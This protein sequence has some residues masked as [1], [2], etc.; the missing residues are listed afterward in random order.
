[1]KTAKVLTDSAIKAAQPAAKPYKLSDAHRLYLLVSTA[2]GKY[3]KWNYR[4]DGKDC[5]YTLGAYP[6]VGLKD[7][8]KKRL[9]AS[10]L[11]DQGIHPADYDEERRKK[12]KAEEAATFWAA[13]EA[14]IQLSKPSW[15][16]YYLKQVETFLRRYAGP[17]TEFGQRPLKK[18]S[19]PEVV[20]LVRGIAVRQEA[21]CLERKS[22][23]AP[24]LARLVRQWCAA[25]FRYAIAS[26]LADRN[27]VMDVKASDVIASPKVKNN[28]ALSGPELRDLL[29][30]TK[31]F[32][33]NRLTAIAIELLMRTFVRTAELRGATWNEID[34]AKAEWTIPAARMKIKDAGD[35]VVPL[36]AQSVCLLRELQEITG[37][38]KS[39]PAWLFPNSR[40]SKECM[41]ATTVNRAL[42]RMG[43]NG[44]NTI[45]FSA[46]GFRGTASTLLHERGTNPEVI[47]AQLA[48]KERSSV[49]AAYNKA[50]YL[51][52]RKAMMQDWSEYIDQLAN[53]PK[54]A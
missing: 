48:H 30:A 17:E 43:F 18:V 45:G 51:S 35:H 19:A 25:V 3:W 44:K 39:A 15:T 5:T 24:T 52:Q 14:W 28:R 12:A 22:T 2:G 23:G 4:L 47:E 16:P 29:T 8:R 42:E 31:A 54:P 9:E 37:A 20:S 13:A 7:A 32:S 53:S 21:S 10:E 36:S 1:M 11:V 34:W 40:D 50:K 38:A 41:S 46:H 6:A 27:P 33:G 26:G 49:K